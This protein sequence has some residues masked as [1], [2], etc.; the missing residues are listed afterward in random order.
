MVP[1]Y[2]RNWSQLFDIKSQEDICFVF[3]G[4]DNTGVFY[5]SRGKVVTITIETKILY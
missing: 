2:V 5:K 4:V 1:R 3:Q